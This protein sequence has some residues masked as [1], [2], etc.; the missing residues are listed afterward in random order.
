[1]TRVVDVKNALRDPRK[2]DIG[3]LKRFDVVFVSR[4]RIANENQF[5]QQYILGALPINFSFFYD[6]GEDRF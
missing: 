1:M 6:L 5:I 4:S 3:P 2:L